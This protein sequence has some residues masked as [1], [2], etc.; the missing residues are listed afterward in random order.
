VFF[1][2]N[3]LN[4]QFRHVFTF[5]GH[6]ASCAAAL[7]TIEILEEEQI[8]DQVARLSQD[9]MKE[10]NRL[11]SCQIVGE[12]RGVGFLYGI[13]IVEDK[14]TKAPASEETML[15]IVGGCKEKGLIIGRNG[16]TVPGYQNI[17]IIAP[18]LSSTEEDL[19]F[20]VDTVKNVVKKEAAKQPNSVTS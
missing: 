9:T 12:V 4:F 17:L 16:D 18:P 5:G 6:P 13:E 10:L 20:L 11:E 1:T 8:P 2:F 15:A 7:K 14:K 3:I 19:Q